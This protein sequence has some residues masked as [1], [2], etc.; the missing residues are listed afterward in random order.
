MEC[1]M[2]AMLTPSADDG[3][4]FHSDVTVSELTERDTQAIKASVVNSAPPVAKTED[5]VTHEIWCMSNVIQHTC[6]GAI[7]DVT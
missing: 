7:E 6:Y 3:P 2:R 1:H 5:R 4:G